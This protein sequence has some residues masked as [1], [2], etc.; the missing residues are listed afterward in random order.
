M[1]RSVVFV[2]GTGVRAESYVSKAGLLRRSTPEQAQ[3]KDI[4][5]GNGQCAGK[6]YC[7]EMASCEEAKLYLRQCGLV[8]RLDGDAS[9]ALAAARG[10]ARAGKRRWALLHHG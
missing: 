1:R 3:A 7:N 8:S 9:K 4:G 5:I 6:R 2:Q 10:G